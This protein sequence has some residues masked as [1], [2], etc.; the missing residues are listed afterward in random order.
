MPAQRGELKLKI[1]EANLFRD[2]DWLHKMKPYVVIEHQGQ[3]YET[4]AHHGAG[5]NPK[6][7]EELTFYLNSMNE[8]LRL[9]VMDKDLGPDDYIGG[10]YLKVSSL[11]QNNGTCDWF[12]LE[13]KSSEAGQ[14]LIESRF[15]PD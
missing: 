9:K 13:Y 3:V 2:T 7:N 5:K 12:P 10:A 6:W 4:R 1:V 14:I 11:C 15:Y 8:D